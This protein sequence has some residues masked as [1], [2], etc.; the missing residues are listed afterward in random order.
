MTEKIIEEFFNKKLITSSNTQRSYKSNIKKYFKLLNKDI[1]SY[2][3]NKT[4]ED[5]ESDLNKAYME[6]EKLNTPLLT[7]KT[8]FNSIKQF[9]FTI[10]KECKKLD[11]WETIKQR[12]RGADSISKE[13]IPNAK[14]LKAVLTHGDACSRAMYLMMAC[15]GMRIGELVALYEEDIDTSVKPAIVNIRRSYDRKTENKIKLMTKTKKKR[16][17]FLT[18]EAKDALTEWLKLRKDY[19][20]T[21]TS[22]SKYYKD[23]DDDRLF[24][25]CDENARTKWKNLVIKS[26][27]YETD[28]ET[29]RLT[30]HPH[31]LRKFFRS[32]LGNADLAEHL[33]GHATGMDKYY[34]NMKIEDLQHEFLKYAHNVTIFGGTVDSERIN[35]LQD[36]LHELQ[37]ENQELK[38]DMDKL[39]RKVLIDNYKPNDSE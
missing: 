17:S 27:L 38:K 6:L 3:K 16:I 7:R 30:L 2:F 14:D 33:M 25:M 4:L 23:E 20:Q 29:N 21:A 1:N 19:I 31:C 18:D 28:N 8:F 34:R 15:T 11:F 22:K 9:M 24:P 12:T 32:Y 5:Y 26:G 35:G 10:D 36:Q 39:M 37:K 13:L